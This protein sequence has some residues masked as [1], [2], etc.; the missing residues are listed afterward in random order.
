M[1]STNEVFFD[2]KTVQKLGRIALSDPLLRNAG[3]QEGDAVDIYFDV[4]SKRIIIQRAESPVT[5]N[6]NSQRNKE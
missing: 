4:T 3:L 6:V 1:K 2:T 5:D